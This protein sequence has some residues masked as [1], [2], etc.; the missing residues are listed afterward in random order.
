MTPTLSSANSKEAPPRSWL[1]PNARAA[2]YIVVLLAINS[3]F[4]AS[5]A[6]CLSLF[7]SSMGG[8]ALAKYR[9]GARGAIHGAL[10]SKVGH[11]AAISSQ[12]LA[13]ER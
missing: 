13:L 9:F 10:R 3:I 5:A 4:L 1:G 12:I 8:Y 6:T 11:E 2:A 7:F